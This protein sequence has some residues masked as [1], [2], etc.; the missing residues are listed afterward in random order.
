MSD[1][2][3]EPYDD[4]AGGWGSARSLV[5]ILSREQIPISG[6]ALLLKQNKPGGFMCV[7]CAWP[8]P[9]KPATFEYCENGAKATAWEQTRK[10][11]GPDFFA[12]HTVAE[13][14]TW[15]DFDLEAQG[16][17]THPLRYDP[18]SDRYAPISWEDAFA[19][20]GRELCGFDPKSVVYYSSGRASLETSYM[21]GLFARLYG[22]NNLPDSSNMCHEP[23]STGLKA[24]I[25]VPVGTTVL[26]DFESTDCIL[27]FG[28]N[29]GSNAPRMLHPLQD[30]RRRKVPIITFNP[31]RE[32]GLKRFTDPQSPVEMLTKSSTRISTQYHQV[33]A[34][35]DIAAITGMCKALLATDRQTQA[36]GRPRVLDA[37][38]IAEH[39]YGFEDFVGFCDRQHWAVLEKRSG[40]TREAL[41]AAAA[42]YGRAERVIGIYGMGLTQHRK[43]TETVQMLVNL[44][45]LRGNIGKPGAGLCPVR[46][47]SN[48]QGQRTVGIAEKP[49]LVPLDRLADLY[50]FE[51]PR[52]KGLN[53]VEACE[54]IIAGSVK[55][56]IGLGGNFVRAIPDTER[57]EE[58][59][60]S[61]RLTV[62]FSTK[63]NRSHLVN[64]AVAYI[65]PC[66]GRIEI[67][68]QATGPQ[69]VSMEDST[70]CFHGSVGVS[71]PVS[72]H[73][74]SE[75]W[76]VAGIAKAT[77]P[78]NPKV[79]WDA[80]VGDYAKVR[81]AIEATYPI[82][83]KDFNARL[84]EPGGTHKP[85]A[86]RERRWD[87]ETGKANFV[88][89]QGLDEDPDM[90]ARH[91]DVLDL[92]TLRSNDQFNTTVYG[93]HD[94]FRG[95]KGTRQVLFMNEVDIARLD[96]ADGDTVDV[97]TESNDQYVRAVKGL[98]VVKYSIPEGNCGGYYPELNVLIPLSHHDK[99]AKTPAAKAIPVR[100][101]KAGPRP[102]P[103]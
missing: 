46:G 60:R 4:P 76:I 27:F 69:A 45:L 47:H 28:Q 73:V 74:R 37:V 59:W 75:P 9:A 32:R 90:P 63:L 99:Q 18:T 66:L 61:M 52:D 64:G 78:P 14:L 31:L 91:A 19:E 72:D 39:T 8:K 15:T 20:I 101:A 53:T 97:V 43:G 100:I 65:L 34:G 58:A 40:L 103:N 82:V 86:A 81:D 6:A 11:V 62:Q 89:P 77:L 87:T 42:V 23:T 22:N 98:R 96:L 49:E 55:A 17:L 5:E 50:G 13:L 3:I 36:E 24:S 2:E 29:V 79:D 95:V 10:R 80:W 30:A 41:E 51:P 33:K 85:L 84:F 92:I 54:G 16:R 83:F 44:M 93:Y 12:K 38:F 67:D 21:Y 7:S 102:M 48:V 35:G 88:V 57:M 71:K 68:E 25:G 70:S 26:E 1:V 56:F 94:R